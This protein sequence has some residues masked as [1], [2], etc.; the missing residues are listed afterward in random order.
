MRET[1]WGFDLGTTSIGFAVV[2]HNA[3]KKEGEIIR[4]GVRI[5]P[6]GITEK[7]MEPRN[8]KRREKRLLRKQLRRRKRRR[9]DLCKKM[10]EVGLLP[11]FESSQWKLLM[12]MNPYLL[13]S[14]GMNR[15]LIPFEFGRA[16]YHLT[17]HRG[18]KSSRKTVIDESKEDD[19][20]GK[21]KS[22]IEELRKE[23]YDTW[24]AFK[25]NDREKTRSLS[26]KGD[27]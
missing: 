20:T 6:E 21:V 9:I 7:E 27:G 15:E 11:K 5:F 10:E 22:S 23:R 13:R 24:P 18:F 26:W 16:L 4:M 2:E 17:Q 12:N 3:K 1:I 19:D 8:K 25:L 14:E